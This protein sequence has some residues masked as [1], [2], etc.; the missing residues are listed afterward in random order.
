MKPPIPILSFI[1]RYW[2]PLLFFA[3][4]IFVALNDTI[5]ARFGAVVYLPMLFIGAGLCAKL[6]RHFFD[7]K[8]LDAYVRGPDFKRDFDQ[9]SPEGKVILVFVTGWAYLL[10]AALIAAALAK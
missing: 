5:F 9:L 6:M 8:T 2:L 3:A 7:G 10:A 4:S 1:S